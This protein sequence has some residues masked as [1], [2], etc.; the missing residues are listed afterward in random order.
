MQLIN[1]NEQSANIQEMLENL[2]SKL[3]TAIYRVN[4]LSRS[5][6]K[7][8]SFENNANLDIFVEME[9]CAIIILNILTF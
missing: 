4:V 6:A 2:K 7:K 3:I 8:K 5:K 9:E 1:S